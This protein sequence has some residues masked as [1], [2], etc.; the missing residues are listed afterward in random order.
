MSEATPRRDRE[1]AFNIPGVIVACCV[2]LFGIHALRLLVSTETDNRIV[3]T[4][5]FVPARTSIALHVATDRLAAAYQALV[6][7]NP[8][9]ASQ[10]DFLL[11]DG[12]ARWWTFV[13]YA[14]LHASWMHV[15]FNCIWLVAFGSAVARRFSRWRFLLLLVVSAAAG[16]VTQYLFDITSFQVIIGASAAVAGA[17]GAAT[18][19]VFRPA[20]PMRIFDRSRIDEAFRRP[21]L[22]LRQ[23][24]TTKAALVFII[25]WFVTNLLFGLIP[26]LGGAGDGLIAWQA[27]LGGFAAGLLLF[28]LF[29][30]ARHAPSIDSEESADVAL[31]ARNHSDS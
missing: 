13:T 25:F 27:H 12:R 18:R 4:F 21:A 24:F 8:V 26:R 22:S 19:F 9:V 10:L 30:P 15:G 23:T 29:D 1:P 2:V 11:G 5:A 16:A 6:E 17:M 3:A 28:P 7:N 31:E 20:A 14:F